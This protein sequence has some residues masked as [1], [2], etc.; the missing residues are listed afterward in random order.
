MLRGIDHSECNDWCYITIK[1][2]IAGGGLPQEE[3]IGLA[4][5]DFP[6]RANVTNTQWQKSI[7]RT[8]N[9]F[10]NSFHTPGSC[11]PEGKTNISDVTKMSPADGKCAFYIDEGVMVHVRGVQTYGGGYA[12][13]SN[14]QAIENELLKRLIGNG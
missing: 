5:L 12:I 14:E 3:S 7:S 13:P 8:K 6:Q 2:S 11:L 9:V 4:V 1:S 10:L